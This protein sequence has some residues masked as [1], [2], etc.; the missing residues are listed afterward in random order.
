MVFAALPVPLA[1]KLR[2]AGAQFFNPPPAD[3]KLVA[4]LVTSFATPEEDV[5]KFLA[6]AG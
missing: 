5:T 6:L 1:E 2:A 4:R 3:G